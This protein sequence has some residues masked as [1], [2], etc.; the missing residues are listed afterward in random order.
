MLSNILKKLDLIKVTLSK[1]TRSEFLHLC[2]KEHLRNSPLYFKLKMLNATSLSQCSEVLNLVVSLTSTSSHIFGIIAN[3]YY[4]LLAYCLPFYLR[5]VSSLINT[6]LLLLYYQSPV[7]LRC[8]L[9]YSV[10]QSYSCNRLIEIQYV[11][12]LSFLFVFSS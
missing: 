10:S 4:T 11:H 3:G 12:C 6:F 8:F 9:L 5:I 1:H 2:L 7:D